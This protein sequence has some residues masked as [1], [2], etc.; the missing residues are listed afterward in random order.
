VELL[1]HQRELRHES[2]YNFSFITTKTEAE[3][4][5]TVAKKF[6]TRIASLKES[7]QQLRK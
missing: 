1:D 5:L 6:V 7:I 2:Q 3:A 4:T